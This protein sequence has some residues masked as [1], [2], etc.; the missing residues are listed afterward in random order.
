MIIE[1]NRR[2]F[3][4]CSGQ[5]GRRTNEHQQGNARCTIGPHAFGLCFE[6]RAS[7]WKCTRKI[8]FVQQQQQDF[9]A[10]TICAM[11][12]QM[13]EFPVLQVLQAAD[14]QYAHT[15]HHPSSSSQSSSLLP[16]LQQWEAEKFA[17]SRWFVVAVV[18]VVAV[19]V[20]VVVSFARR[21]LF[22]YPE[23]SQ[24]RREIIFMC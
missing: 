14:F 16:P 4:V 8:I 11:L 9:S 5:A 13:Q 19:A 21:L 17:H 20:D 1:Q 7:H 2:T 12:R 18:V 10:R 3:S 24:Y 15:S 23:K 22:L 6:F